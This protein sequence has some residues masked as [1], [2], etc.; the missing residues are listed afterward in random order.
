MHRIEDAP[1]HR[2]LPVGDVRQRAAHDHAHCVFEIAALG[3]LRQRKR[4]VFAV[5]PRHRRATAARAALPA[6]AASASKSSPV[7]VS[8]VTAARFARLPVDL[9]LR[10]SATA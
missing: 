5:I 3:K 10:V 9:V 6:S 4:V 8:T 2:L 7:S 1:L